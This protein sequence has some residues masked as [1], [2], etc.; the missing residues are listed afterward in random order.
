MRF[1]RVIVPSI[2]AIFLAI[3]T[4]LPHANAVE[5]FTC[6]DG[7]VDIGETCDDSNTTDGDGCSSTC[8]IDIIVAVCG[9]GAL[10]IGEICD[11]GNLVSF[12]G[13][14]AACFPDMPIPVCGNGI[15]EI[16]EMCD[17]GNAIN[18]DT[19]TN[20]CM[21]NFFIPP[22]PPE[23]SSSSAPASSAPAA[24]TGGG[25]GKRNGGRLGHDTTARLLGIINFITKGD[26]NGIPNIAVGGGVSG[27]FTQDEI[28]DI[29]I[30]KESKVFDAMHILADALAKQIGL[31][32]G[33]PDIQQ[34]SAALADPAFCV[35]KTSMNTEEVK[36][37]AVAIRVNWNGYV[38][39]S[40][41]VWNACVKGKATLG[42]I[43]KNR[44]TVMHRQGSIEV[45]RPLSCDDYHTDS[46][47]NWRHPDHPDLFVKLNEA[48]K[49][50]GTLPSGF[51][52][53]RDA[54]PVVFAIEGPTVSIQK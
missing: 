16:G 39:S 37:D 35:P 53:V 1:S 15:M 26:R 4:I 43:K 54:A 49:L 36:K 20:A 29:C 46:S 2:I 33:R 32:F 30:I 14:S 5:P 42:L 31:M 41:P 40:N 22:P 17:D 48:G 45:Y 23:S 13:C 21:M 38:I 11:D 10:E 51:V 8:Q 47:N 27:P 28:E 19:C 6:G 24:S 3:V 9:N 7:I 52:A 34:I 50:A 25:S 12:D 44:D 18:T